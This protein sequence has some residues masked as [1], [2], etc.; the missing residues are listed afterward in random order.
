MADER[1]RTTDD[2]LREAQKCA[3]PVQRAAYYVD[4]FLKELMCGKCFPCALGS[5]EASLILHDIIAGRTSGDVVRTLGRIS[6]MMLVGSR[7]K[8]GRDTA[9]VIADALRLDS[10]SRHL[11]GEC[12]DR[13][14]SPLTLYRIIPERCTMC[15]QCQAVCRFN[16]IVGERRVPYVSGFLPFEIV[17]RRCTRCGECRKV[18]PE[19][20]VEVCDM[21]E[22]FSESDVVRTVREPESSRR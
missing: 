9:R 8:R 4:E 15:G 21:S 16:A 14:C 18:C 1:E 2:I 5:A 7:C 13:E 17:P 22:A 6:D 11:R 20:A 3:C 10:F 12:P 19:G